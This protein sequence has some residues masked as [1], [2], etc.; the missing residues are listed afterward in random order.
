MANATKPVNHEWEDD[1][2]RYHRPRRPVEVR[3]RSSWKRVLVLAARVL[4]VVAALV[5]VAGTGFSVY[6]F[7]TTSPI[8]RL[9]GFEAVEVIGATQVSPEVVR[10]RFAADIGQ[11]VFVI[12]LEAR[13]ESLNE[14]AW[15]EA[16]TVQRLLPNRL[17][18]SLRQRT[19]VAFVRQAASL[20]LVD[21]E[22]VLL[23]IPEGASY[24]FPVL[25]GLPEGL[26]LDTRRERVQIYLDFIAD[27]G[28]GDKAYS[29]QLS[30]VD[31]SDTE[32]LRAS[33]GQADGVVW[34]I[35]GRDRYQEKFETFLQHRSL[36]EGSAEAVRSVDLRYRGQMVLNPEA[37][38]E[39]AKP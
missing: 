19:P 14:I 27:L 39:S 24:S 29:R 2:E 31:L 35:F 3:R 33:L 10:E 38:A 11:S 16:A 25:A 23:P 32:N 26:P 13:R 1:A 36:L 37:P 8:F 22:G 6:Q 7:A 18:V 20:W 21:G 9:A 5:A 17:R 4:L 34:L 28:R 12:P 15:V 30:E